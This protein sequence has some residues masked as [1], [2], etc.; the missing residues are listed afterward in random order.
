MLA[1]TVLALLILPFLPSH[2]KPSRVRTFPEQH[3]VLVLELGEL[4]HWDNEQTLKTLELRVREESE[5]ETWEPRG[6]VQTDR[7][8]LPA[9]EHWAKKMELP[10]K[11]LPKKVDASAKA[12]DRLWVLEAD[13][14]DQKF[15]VYS[16]D[17]KTGLADRLDFSEP[18]V[19]LSPRPS[20]SE[21][22][23]RFV[24]P[25]GA[26]R[27]ILLTWSNLMALIGT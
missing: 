21:E 18:I 11:E 1:K 5:D 20:F 6:R 8:D 25:V 4:L 22:G 16:V 17:L 2:P 14:K 7:K 15:C 13:R 19:R 23:L 12:K 24:S 27:S 10:H 26:K 3:P 9:I